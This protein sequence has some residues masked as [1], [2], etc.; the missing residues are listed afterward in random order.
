MHAFSR[1]IFCAIFSQ[2]LFPPYVSA[3]HFRPHIHPRE[4]LPRVSKPRFLLCDAF[5]WQSSRECLVFV[6]L[7]FS[8]AWPREL[9]CP[10]VCLSCPKVPPFFH[11]RYLHAPKPCRPFMRLDSSPF[12]QKYRVSTKKELHKSEGKMHKKMK[13]TSQRAE[14]FVHVQQHHGKCFYEKVFF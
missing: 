14:N 3:R 13:M 1:W 9:P 5:Q 10:R 12:H 11:R 8:Q 6:L 4:C 2:T 7:F